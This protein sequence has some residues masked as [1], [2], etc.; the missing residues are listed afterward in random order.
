MSPRHESRG[1]DMHR[2]VPPRVL[3]CAGVFETLV[4]AGLRL[5]RVLKVLISHSEANPP[6]A[7]FRACGRTSVEAD[8]RRG[9]TIEFGIR[10]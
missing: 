6:T 9:F 5:L 3:V 10:K 7:I 1:R 8:H 4:H 2:D